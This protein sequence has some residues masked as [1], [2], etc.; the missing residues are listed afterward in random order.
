MVPDGPQ[1]VYTWFAIVL[2]CVLIVPDVSTCMVPD[3]PSMLPD[4]P[5]GPS[6]LPESLTWFIHVPRWS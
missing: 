5:D 6:M 4:C 1:I 2:T 3:G